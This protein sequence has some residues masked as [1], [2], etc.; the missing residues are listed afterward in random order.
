MIHHENSHSHLILKYRRK[1]K[2]LQDDMPQTFSFLVLI[3]EN[4]WP[5][6][7]SHFAQ[8]IFEMELKAL[9]GTKLDVTL[10]TLANKWCRIIFRNEY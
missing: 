1:V 5:Y 4:I 6:F 10:V 2:P 7:F 3:Y 8:F 9:T